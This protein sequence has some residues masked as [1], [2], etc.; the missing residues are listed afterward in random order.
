MDTVASVLG[1][2]RKAAFHTL[3]EDAAAISLYHF[4]AERRT[5]TLMRTTVADE[6]EPVYTLAESWE[7][8]DATARLVPDIARPGVWLY[9]GDEGG[10]SRGQRHTRTELEQ[11][12]GA[13]ARLVPRDF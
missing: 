7:V 13:I 6:G 5:L 10:S 2:E 3:M 11:I 4:G 12:H 8:A 9:S 1:A